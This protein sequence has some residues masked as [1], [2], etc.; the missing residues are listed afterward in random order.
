MRKLLSPVA[1]VIATSLFLTSCSTSGGIYDPKNSKDE[2]SL[3]KTIGL[4][5]GV[6]AVVAAAKHGGGG[7]NYATPDYAWDYQPKN[8]QWVCRDKTNGQYA[9]LEKCNSKPK[10]DTTWPG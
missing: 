1:A 4:A 8:D 2:F 5:I 7:S 10:I 3:K 6:A 9:K